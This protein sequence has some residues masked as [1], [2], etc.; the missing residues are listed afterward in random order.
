MEFLRQRRGES[1]ADGR[2]HRTFRRYVPGSPGRT[3]RQ[4]SGQ[5]ARPSNSVSMIVDQ[6][7]TARRQPKSDNDDKECD[8]PNR[9]LKLLR[10][11]DF[12]DENS[13]Q[14]S[15]AFPGYRIA[16]SPPAPTAEPAFSRHSH[17]DTP[18]SSVKLE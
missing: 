12:G 14:P 7:S 4:L 13:D 10:D 6:N 8:H 17:R 1:G 15:P 2:Q 18:K 3:E 5:T 11:E 9:T 16:A